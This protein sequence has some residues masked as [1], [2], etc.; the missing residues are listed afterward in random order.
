MVEGIQYG[1][2][3]SSLRWR[4]FSADGSH[5]QYGEGMSSVWWWVYSMD[6]STQ[7]YGGGCA[8]QDYRHYSG[9]S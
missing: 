4:L 2:G 5:Q 1:G 6:L 7:Q 8:V 3:T 9:G